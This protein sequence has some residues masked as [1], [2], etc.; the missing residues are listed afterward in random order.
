MEP[1]K[2]QYTPP[3]VLER[4]ELG[5]QGKL[6]TIEVIYN[7]DG[8][9]RILRKR[10]MTDVELMKFRQSMF[11]FGFTMPVEQGHWSIICPLDIVSVDLFKQASYFPE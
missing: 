4:Q 11:S 6:W 5:R 10:N 9:S 1:A 2:K 3:E 7:K 8:T